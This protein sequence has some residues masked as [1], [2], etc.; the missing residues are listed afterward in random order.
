[1]IGSAE[2][3]KQKLSAAHQTEHEILVILEREHII[4]KSDNTI[5]EESA[6]DQTEVEPEIFDFLRFAWDLN[7]FKQTLID[8]QLDISKLPLGVLSIERIK[9]SN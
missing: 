9:K 5:Q 2:R 4:Q 7:V 1:M 8:S 3:E 6:F